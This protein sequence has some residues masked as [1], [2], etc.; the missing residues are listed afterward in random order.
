[1][2]V[3]L[4]PDHV[5]PGGGQGPGEGAGAGAD[6]DDQVARAHPGG[7]DDPGD[8]VRVRQEVLAEPL[9]RVMTVAGEELDDLPPPLGAL[10]D[11]G[12]VGWGPATEEPRARWRW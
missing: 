2:A 4:E 5:G 9:V 12:A 1:M 6:L 7:G 10:H 8:Q 3:D 11:P